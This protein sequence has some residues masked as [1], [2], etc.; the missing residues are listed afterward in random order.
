VWGCDTPELARRHLGIDERT[1][2]SMSVTTL[3][4]TRIVSPLYCVDHWIEAGIHQFSQVLSPT[5][6][7]L[8]D[9]KPR[10]HSIHKATTPTD[11]RRFLTSL[12]KED[13]PRHASF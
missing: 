9:S 2:A 4:A 6:F 11:G 13:R 3:N 5:F 7:R 12:S 10:L 1:D 8:H